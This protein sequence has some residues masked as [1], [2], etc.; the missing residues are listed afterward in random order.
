MVTC[1]WLLDSGFGLLDSGFW[2]LDFGY[3]ILITCFPND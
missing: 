3:S 1:Y 2:L